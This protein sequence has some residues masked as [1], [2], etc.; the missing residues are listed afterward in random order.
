MG[1]LCAPPRPPLCAALLPRH[2]SG[3]PAVRVAVC[4]AAALSLRCVVAPAPQRHPRG[5]DRFVHR[6]GFLLVLR[7]CFGTAAPRGTMR[8]VRRRGPLCALRR[9]FGTAAPPQANA[10]H[11]PL[12]EGVRPRL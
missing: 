11:P 2:R 5:A 9:C 1:A 10:K 8:Y 4:A 12:E 7:R 6:R 3:T